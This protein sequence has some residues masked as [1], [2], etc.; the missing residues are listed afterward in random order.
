MSKD[1]CNGRRAFL[2]L[3]S[4]F[5]YC[6]SAS[7]F[8][9]DADLFICLVWLSSGRTTTHRLFLSLSLSLSLSPSLLTIFQ[10]M[11]HQLD[12]P[13]VQCGHRAVDLIARHGAGVT[14]H[15]ALQGRCARW[16]LGTIRRG[17]GSSYHTVQRRAEHGSD[18]PSG[19]AMTTLIG[20]A[21][22]TCSM[23]TAPVWLRRNSS[24]TTRASSIK[25]PPASEWH[26]SAITVR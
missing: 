3:V 20:Q 14:R 23:P 1:A 16:P 26:H 6:R 7:F 25:P 24:T 17:R 21:G 4:F 10:I 15:A 12:R 9:S 19:V 2:F 11:F 18:Q 5:C 8:C 13:T 22:G